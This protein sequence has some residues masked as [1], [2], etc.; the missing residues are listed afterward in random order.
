MKLVGC[1][2]TKREGQKMTDNVREI[3]DGILAYRQEEAANKA[4]AAEIKG[5]TEEV[6]ASGH[7]TENG[8]TMADKMF[9]AENT[10]DYCIT[11]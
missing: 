6:L 9:G 4:N 10:A 7:Y 1:I 2:P 8:L 5:V 11:D 3:V